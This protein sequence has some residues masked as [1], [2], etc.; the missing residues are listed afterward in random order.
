MKNNVYT[1]KAIQTVIF[2]FA[3]SPVEQWE[4][5]YFEEHLKRYQDTVQLLPEPAEGNARLLDIGIFPGHI[6]SLAADKG[7]AVHGISNDEITPAFSSRFKKASF[8]IR[9]IDIE[10]EPIP[11]GRDYFD[12]VLFCEVIEHLYRDPFAVLLEIFRVLKP[13]GI[14]LLSTPNLASWENI[15]ELI[16]ERSYLTPLHCPLHELFPENPN[17]HHVREYTMKELTCLLHSQRKYPYIFAPVTQRYSWC[18]DSTPGVFIKDILHPR[19]FIKQTAAWFRKLLFPHYRSSL[20]LSVKKPEKT[21]Y[22]PSGEWTDIS[23]FHAIECTDRNPGTFRQN[24]FR[25]FRWTAGKA[26]FTVKNLIKPLQGYL[27]LTASYPVPEDAGQIVVTC[28]INGISVAEEM[29]AP[30][31]ASQSLIVPLPETARE[32]DTISIELSST[33]WRPDSAGINDGRN[34]GIMLAWDGL[35]QVGAIGH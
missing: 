17:L 35:C 27:L 6:S 22:I 24:P 5:K 12:V 7:Y 2:G 20:I 23:G 28:K 4:R 29:F 30:G 32:A 9:Q 15:Y 1:K 13:G 18:W 10:K 21:I 14:L 19:L 8:E 25:T 26:S 11:Y 16:H 33:T 31:T 34:L 3:D